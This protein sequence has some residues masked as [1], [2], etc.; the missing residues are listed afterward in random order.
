M[1]QTFTKKQLL[2]ITIF[3]I[4]LSSCA[5]APVVQTVFLQKDPNYTGQVT[6]P[7]ASQTNQ[8]A[9]SRP[10]SASNTADSDELYNQK[11]QELRYL[12]N[13]KNFSVPPIATVMSFNSQGMSTMDAQFITDYLSSALYNTKA[14]RIID[15][16]QRETL[17]QELSFSMSGCSEESC[18][19]EMGRLLSADKIIVGNL[20]K[21]SSRF[22][23][24]I[25]MIDVSSGETVS[26][27][28]NIYN[29]MDELIDDSRF[30]A[31]TLTES[32]LLDN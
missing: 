18:Q 30:I 26:V 16:N 22:I 25:R 20:G 9:A 13:R 12:Y 19:L 23:M 8:P 4:F 5:S 11:L 31:V 1:M 7:A 32:F 15:R 17:L 29:S 3:V 27:S 24:D 6:Q 10:A 28:N 14:F 21:I 2:F